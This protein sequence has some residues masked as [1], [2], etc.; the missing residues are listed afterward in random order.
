MRVPHTGVTILLY[1]YRVAIVPCGRRCA[2][3]T[4]GSMR[5]VSRSLV[6]GHVFASAS[7]ASASSASS[8]SSYYYDDDARRGCGGERKHKKLPHSF[9]HHST[10][11]AQ[12]A[13]YRHRT[14]HCFFIIIERVGGS[15]HS[16]YT[17]SCIVCFLNVL[18]S[19]PSEPRACAVPFIGIAI[20][21]SHRALSPRHAPSPSGL[22]R[23]SGVNGWAWVSGL[24]GFIGGTVLCAALHA[25]GQKS[26][27]S[28]RR[29]DV[30]ARPWSSARSA[31]EVCMYVCVCV[32]V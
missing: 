21:S 13:Y 2:S 27:S 9:G 24:R 1:G 16:H 19:L 12:A 28:L 5:G 11:R 32:C 8:A 25:R 3:Y 4:R 29:G 20:P 14:K 10:P 23:W 17:L 18:K 22:D 7:A 26:K 15:H 6:R 30:L 31:Y